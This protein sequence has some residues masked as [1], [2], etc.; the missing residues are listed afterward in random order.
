MDA[1]LAGTISDRCKDNDGAPVHGATP[2]GAMNFEVSRGMSSECNYLPATVF[3]ERVVQL[4]DEYDHMQAALVNLL[5][6]NDSL[7]SGRNLVD[8]DAVLRGSTS[9]SDGPGAFELQSPLVPEMSPPPQHLRTFTSMRTLCDAEA[10][11]QSLAPMV[12]S[13]NNRKLFSKRSTTLDG[14]RLPLRE[15][16]RSSKFEF[17]IGVTTTLN[18]VSMGVSLDVSMSHVLDGDLE[19]PRSF[20]ETLEVV[21]FVIYFLEL[22]F[23]MLAHGRRFFTDKDDR[24]LNMFDLLL[25]LQ[26]AL[27]QAIRHGGNYTFM[28]LLRC[29]RMWKIIRVMRTMRSLRDLR[30]ILYSVMGC[31]RTMFFSFG[32]LAICNY[33]FALVFVQ[34]VV[35]YVR[36]RGDAYEGDE[37]MVKFWGSVY[38]GMDTLYMAGTGGIDWYE[39]LGALTRAGTGYVLVF[40]LYV[41][42]FNFVLLNTITSLFVEATIANA[43]RDFHSSI[44]AEL[45]KKD[46]YMQSL[47]LLFDEIDE[48]G[49]G[50]LSLLEFLAQTENPKM[51]AFFAS[52]DIEIE[53]GTTFF[54]TLSE[55]GKKKVTLD[56]FVTGCIR[57]RGQA[58]S[59]D[60]HELILKMD[61]MQDRFRASTHP[62]SSAHS[63]SA[64]NTSAEGGW[65]R[66]RWD[67]DHAEVSETITGSCWRERTTPRA[68]TQEGPL[69]READHECSDWD[70]D[71]WSAEHVGPAKTQ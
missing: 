42:F 15:L 20:W 46:V 6:G 52:L 70:P 44:R 68:S 71:I 38:A 2:G 16:V 66:A 5:Q 37:D 36:S 47:G 64:L 24:F 27:E 19:E 51:T 18:A 12:W 26:G 32:M 67:G 30:M 34:G 29:L 10:P 28:R 11:V 7:A 41:A 4:A 45:E 53:D 57:M 17:F 14:I 40:K 48:D 63:S 50:E 9:S 35:D 54:N 25:V 69:A 49:D 59:I 23:R 8:G 65:R 1:R 33:M 21:F 61:A 56:Q 3:R 58:R 13:D 62:E 60:L 31:A 43:S 39:C 22:V 55:G